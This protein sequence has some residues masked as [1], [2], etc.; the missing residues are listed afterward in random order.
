MTHS[1]LQVFIDGIIT[2]K[3][4]VD[5]A[6][7]AQQKKQDDDQKHKNYRIAK[8]LDFVSNKIR[9]EAKQNNRGLA[10]EFKNITNRLSVKEDDILEAFDILVSRG[11]KFNIRSGSALIS[12]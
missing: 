12:W 9:M 7:S 10:L 8:I 1:E 4:A 5:I 11:F 2:S 3:Q 6:G